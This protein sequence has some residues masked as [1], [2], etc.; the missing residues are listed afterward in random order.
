MRLIFER[1][2]TIEVIAEAG[3]GRTL[4]RQAQALSPDVVV[5]DVSMPE[6][7]GIDATRAIRRE[8]STTRVLVL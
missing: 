7:N 6:L 5:L 1:G 4:L 2:E 3:D 8:H